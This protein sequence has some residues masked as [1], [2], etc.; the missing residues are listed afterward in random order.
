MSTTRGSIGDQ[1][2]LG[3]IAPLNVWHNECADRAVITG[4]E[5]HVAM[6][7][8]TWLHLFTMEHVA[9]RNIEPAGHGFHQLVAGDRKAIRIAAAG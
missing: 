5:A 4:T 1:R 3:A 7:V 8:L 9:G 2:R 6:V